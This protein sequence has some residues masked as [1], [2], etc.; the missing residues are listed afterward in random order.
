MVSSYRGKNTVP[1]S[2]V[3]EPLIQCGM[4]FSL[5]KYY[6]PAIKIYL[7]NKYLVEENSSSIPYLLQDMPI[8]WIM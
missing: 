8:S 6:Y 3:Q 1:V 7:L 5:T 2:L 4:D